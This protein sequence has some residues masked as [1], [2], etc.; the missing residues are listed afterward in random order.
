MDELS[1]FAAAPIGIVVSGPDR[2]FRRVNP[3]FGRMLGYG[4]EELLGKSWEE[5]THPDDLAE[6]RAQFESFSSPELS[7]SVFEKR[8]LDR[9]GQSVWGRVT[10]RRLHPPEDGFLAVVEDITERKQA[11]ESARSLRILTAKL[12]SI[13]EASPHF[14]AFVDRDGYVTYLNDSARTLLRLPAAPEGVSGEFRLESFVVESD[15]EALADVVRRGKS[16]SGE[17]V[18]LP[19]RARM[20]PGERDSGKGVP[21]ELAVFPIQAVSR[22]GKPGAA[23]IAH[24]ISLRKEYQRKTRIREK[25]LRRLTRQLLSAQEAE[26]ARIARELHDDVTQDL[27]V[28]AMEIGFLQLDPDREPSETT[29]KLGQLHD[30]VTRLADKVR[31]LSH[32]YH[33]S[34]LTHSTLASALE[35]LVAES[36]TVHGIDYSFAARDDPDAGKEVATAVYRIVQEALSNVAKHSGASGASVVLQSKG[37]RISVVVSDDGSGFEPPEDGEGGLGLVS[38]Q[39]R[40]ESIGAKVEIRSVKGE[41]TSV[42]VRAP[43]RIA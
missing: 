2:K 39:E 9:S 31:A 14:T 17:T 11:E 43:L 29:A 16:W 18:F 6:S 40:A 26:R 41:G 19:G 32:Q 4:P 37:S 36:R 23:L 28:M 21:V 13:I 5:V 42:E 30:Q 38:M 7:H 24:D 8:Y 25:R 12:S 22:K 27:S 15:R 3:A 10:L 33:P 20:P 34:V 1:I 35:S